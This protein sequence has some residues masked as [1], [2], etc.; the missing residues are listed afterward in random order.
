MLTYNVFL[1]IYFFIILNLIGVITYLYK[2]KKNGK[3]RIILIG[4]LTLT[5]I[6]I[7]LNFTT[8]ELMDEYIFED[9]TLHFY[10]SVIVYFLQLIVL[11]LY[12]KKFIYSH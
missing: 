3:S 7:L 6:C 2:I 10:A 1:L 8:G 12:F 5:I 4:T 11:I 9:N